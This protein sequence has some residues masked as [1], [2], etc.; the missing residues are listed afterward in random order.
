MFSSR[1]NLQ[2][3]DQRHDQRHARM[4]RLARWVSLGLLC[5]GTGCALGSES[6]PRTIPETDRRALVDVAAVSSE[7]TGVGRIYFERTDTAGAFTA[8][9][10]DLEPSPGAVMNALLAGPTEEERARGLRSPLP[11]E[12][13]LNDARYIGNDIVKVDL[14]AQIFEATGDDL[15]SAVAQIVL[16]LCEITGVER[17]AIVVEGDDLEWPRGDGTLTTEPLTAFDYPGRAVSTQP[18]YPGIVEVD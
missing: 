18:D 10:R 7:D 11:L 14:T 15:V 5:T 1:P 4:S 9:A 2:R 6:A 13:S 16:S 12:L 17:V 3:H 8:V